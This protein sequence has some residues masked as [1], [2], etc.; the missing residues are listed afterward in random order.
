MRSSKYQSMKEGTKHISNKSG[1][2]NVNKHSEHNEGVFFRQRSRKKSVASQNDP[3]E[4]E[5][6]ALKISNLAR[7]Q[8]N[9][10]TQAANIFNDSNADQMSV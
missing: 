4:S 6:S 7:P 3:K 2:K 1:P 10:G 9:E 8:D 5:I